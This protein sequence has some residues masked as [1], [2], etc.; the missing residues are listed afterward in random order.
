MPNASQT[1][2][3]PVLPAEKQKPSV[4]LQENDEESEAAQ[5]VEQPETYEQYGQTYN[6]YDR[7]LLHKEVWLVPVTEVAKRYGVSDVAIRRVCQ[8]LDIPTPPTGYWAKLRAGKPVTPIQLPI[9]SKPAKK[10]GIRTGTEYTPQ[11]EKETLE[12]LG[13]EDRAIVLSV[14][15]QIRIPD[16][17]AKMH[18]T[19]VAHRKTV[20]EWKKKR[21]EQEARGLIGA[22]WMLLSFLPTRYPKKH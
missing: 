16:E 7:E 6:I 14:A 17:S 1:L 11:I 5:T 9:S 2:K 19:I 20:M 10:S 22:P 8:S 18:P 13:E 3:S 4:S 15:M 21:R 12:F